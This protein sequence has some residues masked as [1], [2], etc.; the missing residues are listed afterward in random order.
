[1][2]KKSKPAAPPAS[3]PART[4][5]HHVEV[6]SQAAMDLGKLDKAARDKVADGLRTDL[7][8]NTHPDKLDVKAQEVVGAVSARRAGDC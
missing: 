8:A 3:K 2:A 7:T 1:V 4:T 5:P 6:T